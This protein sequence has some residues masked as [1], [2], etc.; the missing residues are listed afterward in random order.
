MKVLSHRADPRWLNQAPTG[1]NRE[2]SAQPKNA[3]QPEG[4]GLK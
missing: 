4:A 1:L 3:R 2:H